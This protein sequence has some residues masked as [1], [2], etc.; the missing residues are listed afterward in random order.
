MLLADVS[1][2]PLS[3]GTWLKAAT[4]WLPLAISLLEFSMD[5]MNKNADPVAEVFETVPPPSLSMA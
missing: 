2:S 1:V 5:E 4:R 3:P